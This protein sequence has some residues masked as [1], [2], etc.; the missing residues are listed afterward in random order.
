M[1]KILS[2]IKGIFQ[3]FLSLINILIT[4]GKYG[5]YVESPRRK[6]WRQL[7]KLDGSIPAYY[8]TKLWRKKRAEAFRIHGFKCAV[9]GTIKNLQAHHLQYFKNG[10]S[11]FGHEDVA[12]DLRILCKKHHPKGHY[13]AA[14]I[15]RDK[16]AFKWMGWL[17]R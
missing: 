11:I 7:W 3:K 16:K 15:K 10:K 17:I 1:R 14:Q 13:T 5:K 9:C 6:R 12:K 4:G 2:F 8:S